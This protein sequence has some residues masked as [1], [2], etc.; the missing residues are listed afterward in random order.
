MIINKYKRNES[1]GLFL[2]AEVGDNLLFNGHQYTK[3]NLSAKPLNFLHIGPNIQNQ[4][5]M[6]LSRVCDLSE[7]SKSNTYSYSNKPN[8]GNSYIIDNYNHKYVYIINQRYVVG[9]GF[10]INKVNKDTLEIEGR[11]I[12]STSTGTNNA[13]YMG[14]D[15][16]YIYLSMTS[17]I[18]SYGN[19]YIVQFDK[20]EC[21]F[22]ENATCSISS[23]YI[24][25]FSVYYKSDKPFYVTTGQNGSYNYIYYST[26]GSDSIF[27]NSNTVYYNKP[28]SPDG[29]IEG[30]S[31]IKTDIYGHNVN[32]KFEN[33]KILIPLIRLNPSEDELYTTNTYR[34]RMS[35]FNIG[36]TTMEWN[37][38][39]IISYKEYIKNN[40]GNNDNIVPFIS[41]I[42]KNIHDK[43]LQME[44]EYLTH[45]DKKYM[46]MIVQNRLFDTDPIK[47]NCIMIFEFKDDKFELISITKGDN[48]KPWSGIIISEDIK[49]IYIGSVN[50]GLHLY[51]LNEVSMN[52]ELIS[53]RSMTNFSQFGFDNYNYL[54]MMDK[55]GNVE[56]YT[57]HDSFYVNME[58]DKKDLTWRGKEIDT[59]INVSSL[60]MEG[61]YT[62]SDIRLYLDG[63]AVF[64]NGE[65]TI[66]IKT[67]NIVNKVPI[68]ILGLTNINLDYDIL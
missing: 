66:D 48:N 22:I 68:K 65:K 52:Y 44:I 53:Y 18:E 13:I 28:T 40:I 60:T 49:N 3:Q 19:N 10:I 6:A 47:L 21:K 50:D 35:C 15:K 57:V 7:S 67:E 58:I 63:N 16:N 38:E 30:F 25:G 64:E 26:I 23:S 9:D 59:F 41:S 56:R 17:A 11:A 29:T 14:Q 51:K 12:L 32:S 5:S 45:N 20:T 24:Y 1:L 62:V 4:R 33:G 34:L 2:I 46:I 37:R 54:Y 43:Y 31:N 61:K 27:K 39:Y 55:N 8:E 36:G 42:E